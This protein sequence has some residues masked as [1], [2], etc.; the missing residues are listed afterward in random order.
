MP[1]ASAVLTGDRRRRSLVKCAD[2]LF[3]AHGITPTSLDSIASSAGFSRGDLDAAFVDKDA[4][5]EAVL[6]ARH[7][8]W[9]ANIAKGMEA[10]PD[11]RD[12]ILSIFGY[13]EGWFAEETF[14]GCV[15]VNAYAELG[16]DVPW[17]AVMVLRHKTVFSD[18]VEALAVEA[19][20]PV[21]AGTSIAL[22]AEGAQVTAAFTH[23]V[24]PAR[25]ARTAAAMIIALYQ[26]PTTGSLSFF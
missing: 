14:Q 24:A 13:L 12:K 22:L 21:I 20:L 17:V 11:P 8:D 10:F 15:F 7:A 3:N 4:L 16:R 1:L 18:L 5:V 2:E 9:R 19:G 26:V 23:T 6:D 25:E